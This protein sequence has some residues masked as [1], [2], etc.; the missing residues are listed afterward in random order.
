MGIHVS[1]DD[2]GTGYS[3]LSYL[4]RL[5]LDRIK[6]DRTFVSDI[7]TDSDSRAIASM[8]IDL[9]HNLG[10]KVLAEGVESEAQL[11]LLTRLGCDEFQGYF[12]SPAIPAELISERYYHGAPLISV[13][14]GHGKQRTLFVLAE[15]TEILAVFERLFSTAGH[16]VIT[17]NHPQ[18]ALTQMA[19]QEV[20]V[21]ICEQSL[22]SPASTEFL[23]AV[24]TMYPDSVRIIL[25]GSSDTAG[26]IDIVNQASVF[27][28][29]TKPLEE[30]L[31]LQYVEEAFQ[32]FENRC[33]V[34][35]NSRII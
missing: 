22:S 1:G 25:S 7:T 16:Q 9:G 11:Q 32:W 14:K 28:F 17:C 31:L 35:P 34:R 23:A 21:V 15:D 6:I 19:K 5:P 10:L 4:K 29:L 27:K 20:G 3:S 13:A 12:C 33:A 18:S 2:F 8:I 26:I 30:P 24:N